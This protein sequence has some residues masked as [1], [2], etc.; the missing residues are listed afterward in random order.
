M[1]AGAVAAQN[2]A[3]TKSGEP[4]SAVSYTVFDGLQWVSRRGLARFAQQLHRHLEAAGWHERPTTHPKWKS[5]VG[6]ILISELLEPLQQLRLR[7]QVAF[8]PHNVLPAWLPT[9]ASLR[10]LV[11]HDVLFL[12]DENRRNAGNQYRRLKLG[13]SL[14]HADLILTVS[15][16]SRAAIRQLLDRELEVLVVPN[17]LAEPFTRL[18][19][20][21][22]HY[23]DAPPTIL[24]FGG[25]APSKNT[26][27]LIEAVAKLMQSGTEVCLEVAAM[28]GQAALIDRWR[29]ASG[30]PERAVRILPLLSDAELIDAYRRADLHAMPSLGEGFGIPVIEAAR[31]GAVNV[32]TPLHVFREMMGDAAIYSTGFDADSIA[33]ALRAGLTVDRTSLGA[34]AFV[35][36]E[37]YVFAAV[38]RVY[39]GPAL[40]HIA[41]LSCARVS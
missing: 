30:L 39:A 5:G 2:G 4:T 36:S 41:Q 27:A 17:S 19:P 14:H 9:H 23:P 29:T 13:H 26:R 10:V 33:S 7:P 21:A 6:R 37:K 28:S 3:G 18:E 11:L 22:K 35:R 31:T 40:G 16:A 24:H 1:R 25:R 12:M 34:R 20:S 32:L 38:H 8:Y 15:E